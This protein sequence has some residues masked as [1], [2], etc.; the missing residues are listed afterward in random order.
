M[1]S[2]IRLNSKFYFLKTTFLSFSSSLPLVLILSVPIYNTPLD[3]NIGMTM[4]VLVTLPSIPTL[5]LSLYN[6]KFFNL[7]SKDARDKPI[8]YNLLNEYLYEESII[9]CMMIN[10]ESSLHNTKY[11][12]SSLIIILY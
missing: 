3:C 9:S 2:M 10:L 1:S 6:T 7:Y 5:T 11:M 8:S 12:I 4:F